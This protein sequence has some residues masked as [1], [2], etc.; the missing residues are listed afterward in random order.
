MFLWASIPEP[1]AE[2]SSLEFAK[3]LIEEADVADQPGRGICEG[4]DGH[5]RSR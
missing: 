3:F 2:M 1:Y 5:V 4:G